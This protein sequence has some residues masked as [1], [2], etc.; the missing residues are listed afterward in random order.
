VADGEDVIDGRDDGVPAATGSTAS[1]R[2]SM[3]AAVTTLAAS[4]SRVATSR[5]G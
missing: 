1:S 3:T 2:P 4:N 5:R